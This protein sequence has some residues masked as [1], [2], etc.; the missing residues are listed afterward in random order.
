MTDSNTP[1]DA[2]AW[3]NLW[4]QTGQGA[5]DLDATDPV[6]TALRETW[7]A[8]IPW[9]AACARVA[10]VGSGPA[11]LPLLL[12]RLAPGP[13]DHLTWE[14]IDAAPLPALSLPPQIRVHAATDFAA[15]AP[16]PG[17]VD[18]LLSN[19][20]LEYIDRQR[21]ADACARWLAPGGRL[22]AVVHTEHSLIDRT[23]RQSLA[24]LEVA[25]GEWQ[26]V[27]RA[28]RVLDAMATLPADPAQRRHHAPGVREAFN[29]A[30]DDLKQ[31]MVRRGDRSA[32]WIDVLTGLADL[33]RQGAGGQIDAARQR[34]AALEAAYAAE[35][36][37][38]QAMQAAA[39]SVPQMEPFAAA[40][41]AAG[42][43]TVDW[44]P[45]TCSAGPVATVLTA[46][47]P[48]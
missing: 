48:R 1:A 41:R 45:V 26:L 37:R 28:G 21:V 47:R 14:C 25:F 32:V 15:S 42:L 16:P 34:L 18:A 40:L 6:A 29:E 24:D 3:A 30:V 36:R 38:L 43:Q 7:A 10:D 22:C 8:Q 20:G 46:N 31:R 39:L 11:V 17:G 4:A 44:R 23:T 19:F 5:I 35:A 2:S 12:R 13:L 27:A 33:L 9:L